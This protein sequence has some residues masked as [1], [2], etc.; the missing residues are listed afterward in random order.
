MMNMGFDVATL[1]QCCAGLC[2]G[3]HWEWKKNF[4]IRIL[5]AFDPVPAVIFPLCLKSVRKPTG[6]HKSMNIFNQFAHVS[7]FKRLRS[8]SILLFDNL[9]L[10][11]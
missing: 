6:H 8:R 10:I 9:M 4:T 1:W 2:G 7:V 11:G 3:V 5:Y